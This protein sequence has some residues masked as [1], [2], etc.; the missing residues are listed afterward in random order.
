MEEAAPALGV[1]MKFSSE[2]EAAAPTFSFVLPPPFPI[3][4]VPCHL[5]PKE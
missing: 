3:A 1:R 4:E 2:A 5:M